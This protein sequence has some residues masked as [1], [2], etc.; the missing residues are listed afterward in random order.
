[1]SDEQAGTG[2]WR[3]LQGR[4]GQP[5]P[6]G[7][8]QGSTE[9]DE[10]PTVPPE[11]AGPVPVLR[12]GG[13]SA[14]TSGRSGPGKAGGPGPSAAGAVRTGPSPMGWARRGLP[15]EEPTVPGTTAVMPVTAPGTRDVLRAAP[16]RPVN[17]PPPSLGGPPGPEPS[18][19][20]GRERD[21][22]VPAGDGHRARR[23]RRR[24]S[25]VAAAAMVAGL[26]LVVTGLSG[27][28]AR[29]RLPQWLARVSEA[30]VGTARALTGAC[31]GAAPGAAPRQQAEAALARAGALDR[32]VARA[33]DRE[34]AGAG[35]SGSSLG[36]LM[37]TFRRLAVDAASADAAYLSWARD[38]AV[39]GC[40]GDPGYD[41][42]YQQGRA[43][44]A[45]AA[46]LGD[47]LEQQWAA[48]AS[49][50]LVPPWPGLG[51]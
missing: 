28:S 35:P 44:Q 20:P 19:S 22:E 14:R 43:E 33:L 15:A 48:A 34:L 2:P 42:Y 3:N 27:G 30:S 29:S 47:E 16:P 46:A 17:G 51:T 26:V 25:L 5:E 21:G 36:P 10:M 8:L 45:R 13:P 41:V 38:R 31:T 7:P 23:R 18:P 49:R 4:S 32:S 11:P 40:Y 9:V 12:W 39:A 24:W 50:H 1:M 37:V 6:P